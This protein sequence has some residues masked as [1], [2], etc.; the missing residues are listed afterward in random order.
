VHSCSAQKVDNPAWSNP[1]T[2]DADIFCE[3]YTETKQQR[4]MPT[5][6]GRHLTGLEFLR[7]ERR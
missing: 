5:E 2:F 4:T 1:A 7:P 3:E 6:V